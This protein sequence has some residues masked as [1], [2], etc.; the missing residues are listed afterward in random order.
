MSTVGKNLFFVRKGRK[1]IVFVERIYQYLIGVDA[2]EA[3]ELLD[4]I[5]FL[6]NRVIQPPRSV[7]S[8]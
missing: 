7:K 5:I 3:S 4:S 2:R 8:K 6:A 1:R